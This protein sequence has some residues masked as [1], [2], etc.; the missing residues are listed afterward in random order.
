M[1]SGLILVGREDDNV[2]VS[3][4]NALSLVSSVLPKIVIIVLYKF[5]YQWFESGLGLGVDIY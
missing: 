2:I 4:E 1:F 3:H 5:P